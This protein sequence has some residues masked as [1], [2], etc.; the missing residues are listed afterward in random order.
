VPL[1]PV[2]VTILSDGGLVAHLQKHGGFALPGTEA[3]Q[4]GGAGCGCG[5]SGSCAR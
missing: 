5:A 3:C 1:P 4:E 2:M